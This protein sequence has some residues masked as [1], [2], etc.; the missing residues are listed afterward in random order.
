[1]VFGIEKFVSLWLANHI[2]GLGIPQ[3]K[4]ETQSGLGAPCTKKDSAKRMA[5]STL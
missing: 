3:S 1:M 5:R 2:L 4:H